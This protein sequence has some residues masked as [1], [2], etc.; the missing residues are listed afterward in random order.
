[1]ARLC[2]IQ[3]IN[4]HWRGHRAQF[5]NSIPFDLDGMPAGDWFFSTHA[6]HL[7]HNDVFMVPVGVWSDG[8]SVA[9]P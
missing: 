5:L 1:M 8:T 7:A 9:V 3:R 6:D 2:G 4:C